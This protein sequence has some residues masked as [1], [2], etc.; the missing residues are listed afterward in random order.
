MK[1][2][3]RMLVL[4]V[5]AITMAA[6]ALYSQAS[7]SPAQKQVG[8]AL[9]KAAKKQQKAQKKAAKQQLKAQKKEAKQAIQRSQRTPYTY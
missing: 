8:K 1:K 9:R 4:G 7:Q 5:L 2:L 6:P 3:L